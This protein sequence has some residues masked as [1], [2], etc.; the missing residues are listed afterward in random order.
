MKISDT[1][2]KAKDGVSNLLGDSKKSTIAIIAGAAILFCIVI[3]GYVLDDDTEVDNAESIPIEVE[4]QTNVIAESDE[5]SEAEQETIQGLKSN[6]WVRD[7]G[8]GTKEYLVFEPDGFN[9][10]DGEMA[11]TYIENPKK[12][13]QERY[14]NDCMYEVEYD[15][16]IIYMTYSYGEGTGDRN[17][18]YTL[19]KGKLTIGDYE[20]KA[21]PFTDLVHFSFSYGT[22]ADEGDNF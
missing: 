7:L 17:E 18:Y 10:A 16:G 19:S 6:A 21:I 13:L 22:G 12:K 8:D 11:H 14:Y 2:A 4:D 5:E 15:D 3:V 9:D 1:F 20:Y